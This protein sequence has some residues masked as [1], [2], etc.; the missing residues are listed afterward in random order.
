MIAQS[1]WF[2]ERVDAADDADPFAVPVEE[3]GK[4]IDLR[5]PGAGLDLRLAELVHREARLFNAGITCAIK[6]RPDTTCHACP[7][8][9]A[10]DPGSALGALCRLGRQ[11]EC[12]CTEL[13]VLRCQGD[14]TPGL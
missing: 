10:H 2:V 12:V 5:D 8:S 11:Q 6:E 9:Q 7:I 3:V 13:A 1:N 4:R 14:Q